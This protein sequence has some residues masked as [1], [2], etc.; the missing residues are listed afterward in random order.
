M[1]KPPT[2]LLTFINIDGFSSKKELIK[3]LLHGAPNTT[4]L[5]LCETKLNPSSHSRHA[6]PNFETH[7]YPFSSY[8][9]GILLYVKRGHSVCFVDNFK[10]TEQG[11]MAVFCDLRLHS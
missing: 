6:I 5:A 3:T 11:T 2:S 4:M 9:S 1:N 7:N 8:S 10:F